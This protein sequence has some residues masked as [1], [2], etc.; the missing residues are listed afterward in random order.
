MA[1][2]DQKE[3]GIRPVVSVAQSPTAAGKRSAKT[4]FDA[5]ATPG[6]V[7]GLCWC[8]LVENPKMER[9]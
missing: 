7:E 9:C 6:V 3:S 8:V 5:N 1:N 4:R 2:T